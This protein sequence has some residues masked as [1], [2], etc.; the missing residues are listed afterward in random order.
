MKVFNSVNNGYIGVSGTGIPIYNQK[1]YFIF[2]RGDRSITNPFAAPIP[3]VLR[4]TGTLFTPANLPPST[5]VNA[6]SSASVG[7]PYAS[8]IDVRN[9]GL[10]GGVTS[11]FTVWDPR[12][13]STSG[14]GAFQYLTQIGGSNFYAV[15]GGTASYPGFPTPTNYIQSGQA[16]LAQTATG[17][18][19]G[20][21]TFDESAK[22]GGNSTLFTTPNPVAQTIQLFNT[23][24]SQ[25]SATGTTNVVDG[26]LAIFSDTYSN[27]I[28]SHDA[29]KSMNSAENLGILTGGKL[30][31]V[32]SRS[33]INANDTIFLSLS[34]VS[35]RNYRLHFDA[36]NLNPLVQGYLV[37]LYTN[38][39]TALNMTGT[40]DVNF[41][42][43]SVAGSYAAN[44]F[45]VVFAPAKVL[46]VTFTSI[47]ATQ[48]GKHI[49]V[50]WRVDN[51]M[52]IN[53]YEVEKSINGT[54]FTTIATATPASN[55]GRSAVYVVADASPVDGYNYYRVKSVDV[56]GAMNYSAIVKVLMGSLQ[57][58]MAIYPNPVTDGMIHLQLKNQPQ[59]YYTARLI[60]KLGQV[61]EEQ[62]FTYGGGNGTQLIKCDH[63]L[64]HGMYDLQVTGPSNSQTTINVMY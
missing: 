2:V 59:G 4:T 32:D 21:I 61:I 24:L 25:V 50:Q 51:E 45:M 10:T 63:N 43:S 31:A 34:G 47:T 23:T 12:L 53:Q 19:S 26:A 14:Y 1:G 54:D 7:N 16:F 5:L 22:A 9:I 60:N 62:P 49:D 15:P 30:L 3:T 6:S 33:T 56:N 39:S 17:G 44:R 64:A 58:S 35:A 41:T 42:V 29:R 8:A 36:E 27:D 37:D 52:N 55:N 48:Q 46:P 28:E 13:G 40:T 11:F 20:T 18:T 38:S 57:Q